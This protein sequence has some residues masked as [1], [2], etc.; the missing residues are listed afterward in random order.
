MSLWLKKFFHH[1]IKFFLTNLLLERSSSALHYSP[2]PHLWK[3]RVV[4]YW[5]ASKFASFMSMFTNVQLVNYP[6]GDRWCVVMVNLTVPGDRSHPGSQSSGLGDTLCCVRSGLLSTLR[7]STCSSSGCGLLFY[8]IW[9][10]MAVNNLS[11]FREKV[12][13]IH[14]ICSNYPEGGDCSSQN[15]QEAS[16]AWR[17]DR[18]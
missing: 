6:I 18:V 7:F 11:E 2:H 17:Q 10:L 3:E 13:D 16:Q 4:P 8:G 12:I 14:L 15:S 1:L 5:R 9:K